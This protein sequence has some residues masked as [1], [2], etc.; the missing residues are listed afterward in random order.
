MRLTEREAV[1]VREVV[2][3]GDRELLRLVLALQLGLTEREAL[4]VGEVVTLAL[5]VG[6]EEDQGARRTNLVPD[7]QERG[8]VGGVKLAVV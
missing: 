3:L 8:K 5:G 7:T 4:R 2:A 1:E 6:D